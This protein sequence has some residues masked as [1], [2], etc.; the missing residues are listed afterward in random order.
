V[1]GTESLTPNP[2]TAASGATYASAVLGTDQEVVNS[3]ALSGA[4]IL[5]NGGGAGGNY[6][7]TMGTNSALSAGKSI[8]TAGTS[9]TDLANAISNSGIGISAT[10]NSSTHELQLQSTNLNTSITISGTPTLKDNTAAETLLSTHTGSADIPGTP[11]NAGRPTEATVDLNGAGTSS[12]GDILTGSIALTGTGGP[13]TFTM[14]TGGN[15]GTT[16][17]NL[18]DAISNNSSLGISAGVTS[19]GLSLQMKTNNT[20]AIVMGNNNLHDTLGNAPAAATLGTFRA[21]TDT[22]SQG[23]INFTV[24]NIAESVPTSSTGPETVTQLV[25]QINTGVNGNQVDPYGVHANWDSGSSTVDLTSD[26]YGTAGNFTAMS[27]NVSDATTGVGLS[28][29]MGGAYNV[30]ITNST[31]THSLYDSS[32]QSAP[33][34]ASA[35][36]TNFVASSGGSAGIATISYSDGAGVSLSATDLSNQNDAQTALTGLNTAITAVAAQDGY[37]GAQ[38]NTLNA[39][40]QVLSTQQENVESAQNAVQATDY[41]SA[42]SNMS[43]YEILSQTGIAALAQANSIQ[44]EVTKLL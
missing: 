5:N 42:T 8:V 25:A 10:V 15:A 26:T 13:V 17:Q 38:I 23:Q 18:A 6:T 29:T 16:L 30:G 28:Y 39:V 33:G 2:G 35:A 37:I 12:A 4:I 24:N 36:Y 43:K 14:G 32:T 3:D 41:A 44:Q 7:F 34:G 20:T 21:D 19:S 9:I 31:G 22:L 11:Y 27:S 1:Y 40:S